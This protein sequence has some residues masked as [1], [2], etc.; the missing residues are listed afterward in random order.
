MLRGTNEW[1]FRAN[2]PRAQPEHPRASAAPAPSELPPVTG[3]TVALAARSLSTNW[4]H[5]RRRNHRL[6]RNSAKAFALDVHASEDSIKACAKAVIAGVWR[7][8]HPGQQ[9]G[10]HQRRPDA[11][12]EAPG[13]GRRHDYQPYRR[14]PV[15]AG[16]GIPNAQSPLGPHHQHHV[17]GWRDRPGRSRPTTPPRRPA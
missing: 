9:C 10:H 3:A 8:P 15:D 14:L 5:R 4:S 6:R 13:L 7:C 17:C 16:T 11:A 12:H 1:T 2:C